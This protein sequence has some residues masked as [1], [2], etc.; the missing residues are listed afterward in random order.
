M[1]SERTIPDP[2]EPFH[3]PL[4]QPKLRVYPETRLLKCIAAWEGEAPAEP[5]AER[6][7]PICPTG[8]RGLVPA[9]ERM[10]AIVA[11]SS[12]RGSAEASP[13]RE[14]GHSLPERLSS[15]IQGPGRVRA[16]PV[17][18]RPNHTR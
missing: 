17:R 9:G 8:S 15:R 4:S 2:R 10:A 6:A 16:A 13:S 12:R 7:G 3:S 1:K 11:E 14:M 18:K 5:Q